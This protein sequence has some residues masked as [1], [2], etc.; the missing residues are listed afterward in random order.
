M[1][2]LIGFSEKNVLASALSLETKTLKTPFF[3][4][5]KNQVNC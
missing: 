3:R 1:C 2:L 4:N 5:L